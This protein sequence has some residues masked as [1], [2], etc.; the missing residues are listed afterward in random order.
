MWQPLEDLEDYNRL[1]VGLEQDL[2]AVF[3]ESKPLSEL[4]G[5]GSLAA[6]FSFVDQNP[7]QAA[8]MARI[9]S[10]SMTPRHGINVALL[11]R[12]WAVSRHKLGA[13]ID[14]FS[15]AALFH[16]LGHWRPASHVYLYG[17]YTHAEHREMQAHVTLDEPDLMAID[18]DIA[19]WIGQHHE[20]PDGRGYPEGIHNPHVLA[21]VIRIVDCYEGLTT[22]RRFRPARSAY[23][24]MRLMGRWAG[25]KFSEA[26]YASFRSFLGVYPVGTFVRLNKGSGIILPPDAHKIYCLVLTDGDGDSLEEPVITEIELDQIV[27]EGHQWQE[28]RLPDNWNNLRPDLLGLPRSYLPT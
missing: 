12:A 5:S 16:D 26:L 21:Q 13:R 14:A 25:I 9:K 10:A 6:L 4:L 24:A 28:T 15:T 23:E 3:R 2:L 8:L 19:T 18:P 17:N 1:I 27:K 20:Q 22:P 11:A 7:Y